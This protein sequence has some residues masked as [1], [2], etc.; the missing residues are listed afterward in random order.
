MGLTWA[1]I[2]LIH[3]EFSYTRCQQV[4]ANN[5]IVVQEDYLLSI[6]LA[7]NKLVYFKVVARLIPI[8]DKRIHAQIVR[9]AAYQQF[10]TYNSSFILN[11]FVLLYY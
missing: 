4:T 10:N 6:S 7:A 2:K 1:R 5:I 11:T 3:Q 9:L 8:N